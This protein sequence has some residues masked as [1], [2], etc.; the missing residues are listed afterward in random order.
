VKHNSSRLV[1]VLRWVARILSILFIGFILLLLIGEVLFPHAEA[2]F[3][4]RDIIAMIFFPIGVVVG[5]IL[6]WRKELLGGLVAVGSL[7]AFYVTLFLFDGRFPRGPFFL[8]LASPGGSSS[9]EARISFEESREEDRVE[10]GLVS[11][12]AG[13]PFL[14]MRSHKFQVPLPQQHTHTIVKPCLERRRVDDV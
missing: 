13:K 7:A 2:V 4:V 9:R 12:W 11:T 3:Q 10:A 6:A 8:L 5:L 14:S 1:T